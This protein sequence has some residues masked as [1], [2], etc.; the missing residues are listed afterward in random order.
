MNAAHEKHGSAGFATTEDIERAGL[1]GGKGL[2]LGFTDE[3]H[4][5]AIRYNDDISI[6]IEGS[7]GSAKST[8]FF[9]YSGFD[10]GKSIHL[11]VKPENAPVTACC[12]FVKRIYFNPFG[13]CMDAPWFIPASH[14]LNPYEVAD[15]NK[16]DFHEVTQL[17]AAN[18]IDKPTGSS[19]NAMHFY[20]KAKQITAEVIKDGK[21]HS[22]HFSPA[23]FYNVIGD[24][25]TGGGAHFEMHIHRM[26]ASRYSS[27]RHIAD[28]LESKANLVPGEFGS[29]MSTITNSIQGLGSPA[30][31]MSLSGSSTMPIREFITSEGACQF[32]IMI[33]DY[34]LE[35]CASVV[36]SIV[37]AF[38][39][40]QQRCRGE[41]LRIYLDEAGQMRGG[42]FEVVSRVYSF[43]RGIKCQMITSYQGRM[44]AENCLGKS[45]FDTV[46]SN[47]QIKLIKGVGSH[48]SGKFVSDMLGQSTYR[49]IPQS[50]QIEASLKSAE[51]FKQALG[52][53]D[54]AGSMLE[55][56]RQEAIMHKPDAVARPLWTADEVMRMPP[57]MGLLITRGLNLKPYRYYKYP[58]YQNPAVAH[59]YL[60]NPYRP[61]YDRIYIPSYFGRPKAVKIISE[62]VPPE[63]AHLPQY[64]G[65]YWSY[66]EGFNPLKPKRFKL[67]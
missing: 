38:T 45:D 25:V 64:Q 5:R 21:T 40:E 20:G 50:Q 10:D 35:Q 49:Y 22:E 12:P 18:Q 51:A 28:E 48:A 47:A 39:I 13:Q 31:Q 3:K 65:G 59:R 2:I 63:I 14:T 43:G 23:D 58:Y 15:P 56:A 27:T 9:G 7:S 61:P 16:P 32:I 6:Y 41:R 1:L 34:L 24:L 55:M 11:D 52:G 46:I 57:E 17:L 42:G 62:K 67:F 54:L 53:G 19:G 8:S 44:Q 66:P 60:P 30:M 4:P 36:R 33:P 26:K 29:I 37:C